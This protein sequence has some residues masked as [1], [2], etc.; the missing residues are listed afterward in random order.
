MSKQRY[1]VRPLVTRTRNGK[2][3]YI[4][5]VEDTLTGKVVRECTSTRSRSQALKRASAVCADLNAGVRKKRLR[6]IGDLMDNFL[7]EY[8]SRSAGA[9]TIH[10]LNAEKIKHRLGVNMPLDDVMS[11]TPASKGLT[12]SQKQT[13]SSAFNRAVGDGMWDRNPVR[14]AR[15]HPEPQ[16]RSAFE[17]D[18]LH[19]IFAYIASRA[20]N[21]PTALQHDLWRGDY[22]RYALHACTGAR[23][24][25]VCALEYGPMLNDGVWHIDR[26]VYV[27]K[28][29][30]TPTPQQVM[31]HIDRKMYLARPKT[32]SSVRTVPV[33]DGVLRLLPAPED[34]PADRF[35]FRSFRN[36]ILSPRTSSARWLDIVRAS[37]VRPRPL[38]T[39]RDTFISVALAELGLS[40]PVVKSIVGHSRKDITDRYITVT[41]QQKLNTVN[42]VYD[43]TIATFP[44][45]L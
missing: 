7:A 36:P 45:P 23:A 15:V 34:P 19:T 40:Y 27:Q 12:R 22:A 29:G 43:A 35:V 20:D 17:V 42:A 6:T 5:R 33:P 30:Y 44:H 18:E 9:A 39:L 2:P 14:D 8:T 1:R 26:Q 38:H 37:G 41:M 28:R 31:E 24:A 25:E 16:D 13:L 11:T 4:H 10:T 3:Q 32:E 21:A